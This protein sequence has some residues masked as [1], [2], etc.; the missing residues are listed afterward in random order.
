MRG[1]AWGYT[2]AIAAV[3]VMALPSGAAAFDAKL[4]RYP[5]LTDLVGTSVMVNFGTDITATSAVVKYGLNGTTCDTNTVT[6][7]RTF[8]LVNGVSEYQ[9]KAQ[10]AGLTPDTEYCYRV[11]FGS[12]QLDLLAPDASP[13]FRSQIP[14]GSSAPFKFAVW[15]NW[16]KTLA[17][18]N[19]HQA[20]VISQIAQSGARFA[21]TAGDNAYEAGSQKSYGDL[22]QVGD[23]TSA[24]FGPS[25]WK[26]AGASLPIFPTIG[27]H[28]HNNDV[29]LTN[30]P[31]DTAVSSSGGQYTTQTYCCTNGTNQADYPNGWYAFDAGLARFY[32]LETAWE[33]QNVGTA[34]LFKNDFDNHW[35]PNSPQYQW[36][37][38]D[39]ETH[40]RALRFAFHHFPMYSDQSATSSDT[41]LQGAN[42]LEGL[43]KLH[44]VTVDFAAHSH[45]YQRNS[46]PP[47]GVPN[48][49]SGGGGANLESIGHHSAG[50]SAMNQY[51]LG[52]S[53]V[54]D[55]G[56]ACGAAPV[57]T[58]KDQ[59]HHFLLV[60]VSG[61][62][63]TVTPTNSLGGTFDPITYN[64]PAQDADISVTKTDSPDP[65]LAG[66]QLTYD[67][68]VGNSGP[69][70]ATGVQLTDT[71]PSS[72]TFESATPS[73]GTCSQT[74]VIVSCSLGTVGNGAN[75]TVQIKVR[76]QATGSI[77]NT[78]TVA[79]NVNDPST[80]N[81]SASAATTV[82]PGADL[83]I[84][85]VDSPDPVLAGEVLTYAVG[86][87]NSGPST[88][89]N[90]S[91]SDTLPP[92]SVF[93][94]ATP[95]QGSCSQASG[96]VSC[97]IGNL[98][99]G[100]SPSISIQVRPQAAGTITSSASITSLTPDTDTAN[101]SASAQT[102]VDPAADLSITK[103]DSP[104][105]VRVGQQLTYA[106]TID[107]AGLSPA[108]DVS[109]SDTLPAGVTFDSATP[110]QGSC[111]EASGT[112]TC[113]LGTVAN[114][115]G[116]SVSITVTPQAA[117][118][119]TNTATVSSAVTDPSPADNSASAVTTVD[120]VADL[121][122]TKTDF[123]DPVLT[124]GLLTYT[125]TVQNAGPSDATGVALTDT[126][127][128]GVV[129]VSATPSQGSC[130]QAA[131]QV[132]CTLG[133]LAASG[134]ANAEV[135]VRPQSPGTITNQ[136]SITSSTHDPDTGNNTATAQTTVEPAADLSLTKSDSPD[137]V[138]VG[139]QLTYTLS[140]HNSGPAAATG[141]SLTDTLPSG[142]TFDSATPTQG[143]CSQASGTVTCS[144]GTIAS[145]V[146]AGVEIKVTPQAAGSI[147]NQ[148]SVSSS[149]S[150]PSLANNSASAVTTVDPVADLSITK[151]DSPDPVS[152]GEQLTYT[153]TVANAGPSPAT[154]V[155]VT[156]TLPGAVTYESATPSQG[157]CSEA[158]GTV[159][160]SLGTLASGANA[161]VQIVVRPTSG[162][163]ITNQASVSSP[164]SDPVLVNNSAS[165]TTTVDPVAD[166]AL[167]KDDS[168]DPVLSGQQ[169]TYT[170]TVSN[171]GPAAAPSVSLS[172]SLPAGATFVSASATQ[173]S[174]ARVGSTVTCALGTIANGSN[175]TVEI[176]VDAGAP[177]TL[178][179]EATVLS[180]A[181]DPDT[182][183]NSASA[184]TTVKPVADLALTKSDAPDPVLAGQL[185]TYTLGVSNGGPHDAIG[186]TV[187]DV[188]PSNSTFD[189]ASASQGS[190]SESAGT[191]TCALGT[192]ANG[193]TASVEIKVRPNNQ[194]SVTNEASVTSE[195][196]DLDQSNN[197]ASAE[198]TVDHAADLQL[199]KTDSPDPVLVGQE[200]TY[201]LTVHNDG[202]SETS[203]VA[204]SDTLPA[205]VTFISATTT[206]G[207]C[208]KSGNSV[209]CTLG[210]LADEETETVE[211]KVTAPAVGTLTNEANVVGI[212]VD[213]DTANNAASADTTVNPAADL[214]LTKS[215]S[216]DPVAAGDLLTYTLEVSNA[217][218]H[219]ATGATLTDTLPAGVLYES[220][221]PTQGTCSE[222]SGTVTCALGMIA[223]GA[224]ASVEVKVRPQEGGQITN[225]AAVSSDVGDPATGNNSASAETTVTPV[226]DL[227]LTKGDSPD[228]VLA[229]EPLT[230]LLTAQNAGP[231]SASAVELID[232]LPAGVTFDSATPTQGTCSESAGTVTC[233]LGAIA[234][235]Q[236]A[237]V[238]IEIRAP[239][240]GTITNQAGVASAD[241]DPVSSN[242]SASADT[243]V[244]AAAD[245]SLTKT[246]SPDPVLEGELLTYSLTAHN[247]GPQDA[248]GVSLTDTLPP[249]VTYDSATPTQGTCSELI[250]TVTC[251]L[252]TVA[253]GADA[254]VEIK[255]R[256]S[257]PGTLTN[258]A[259]VTSDV[260]DPDSA[261]T[262]ASAE[263]TVRPVADLALTKSD[264]PDPVLAGEL[265]TYTLGVSNSGPRDATAT[266]LTDTLPA[267]VTFDSATPTQG[268]C[269]E[270]SGTVTC[271]LGTIAD[272]GSASVEIKV[273]PQAAGT[274]NN[275]ASVASDEG[276]SNTADNSAGSETTVDPAADLSLTKSDSPDPVLAGEPLIYSLA[277]QN[278][279]PSSA[280]DVTLSDTLPAGVTYESATPTQ[281]ICSESGGTVTC[282]LGTI[283]DQQSASVE[284]RI[285]SA[286]PGLLS[287]SA[288]VVSLTADPDSADNSA[289]A[290]TTVTAAADLSLTKS[291][292]PDPVDVGG[293]LTY[294]LAVQNAGPQDATGASLTDTLPAGV[295]YES[296]TPSQGSCS[297]SSGTVTCALGTI[298]NGAGASVELK[299]RPQDAGT[300]TN[301]AAVTSDLADPDSADASAS[302]DTIVRA[303]ADLAL[304]KGDS[305][306]PVLVGELITYALSASNSG[307][308]DATGVTLTDTLPG[309]VTFESATPTQGSC[310]ESAGTVTCALGTIAPSQ[311]ASVVIE[312]RA[313]SPGTITNQAS[314]TSDVY[315][316]VSS[317]DSA[318]AETTVDP[319]ADLSL[320][321]TDSPDP[322]LAGELVAYTLTAHNAGPHDATGAT[323]TDPLPAGVTFDSATP[324]QGSCSESAG[325]V[326]CA[327]GTIADGGTATIQILVR[328][329][330]P[331][332]LSNEA[333]VS[334]ELGDPSTA[335]N[336]ATAET[337][338]TA[339]PVGYPRPAGASP[340]RASLVPAYNE[341]TAPNRSHGP[342]LDSP[343]CNPPAQRSGFLTVGTPD[344]N[345][346][347]AAMVGY[348]R[349]SSATGDP[350]TPADE[351]DVSIAF[352]T[353]DVRVP[354][355]LVDYTGELRASAVLRLTDRANG[356]TGNDTATMSGTTYAFTV[357]CTATAATGV[358]STCSLTTTA[359]ALLPN[360]VTEGK[361]AI[362]QL[363]EILVLD[364][365]PDGDAETADNTV[366]LR[367][368]LFIP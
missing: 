194:G 93:V 259:T 343:S 210:T 136:A 315:D 77:T 216:P 363:G 336:S 303:V 246:D 55:V 128:V 62:S 367:Q 171:S 101:N 72:V 158:S 115:A 140:V 9:W 98:P 177:G 141:T 203:G 37:K 21:V 321:T 133:A 11:Y 261:D 360:T 247:S 366:F 208:F 279:G 357:P 233:A 125:L 58:G 174:C 97:S 334:S 124:D 95:T 300:I 142:V 91:V 6:A 184:V 138:L 253:S 238:V 43:L 126:L 229:G 237:S 232:T 167:T 65:V 64:A 354:G 204:L 257:G 129:F 135:K 227:A 287:N 271:A 255:V 147:T 327:L 190:C 36:L 312:I 181:T 292:S 196:G 68:T 96:T 239:S 358:G 132:E 27:N 226:A 106:V 356:A 309:G 254:G 131:G 289:S 331:G 213:P 38:N 250:G 267:G 134:S 316:P 307:P 214:S 56:Y 260:A 270:A 31:Q 323:L 209:L 339:T 223:N 60:S 295:T 185:L 359:D 320:T 333:S 189:S 179:N 248:T 30:F 206:Q 186:V 29:L 73:Q 234:P 18:G 139:Q 195:A 317:N 311:Q 81:N 89:T 341:C 137:P 40:P 176:K 153:L 272:Q 365:G 193:G 8:I 59:V 24:V 85:N 12:A 105:P 120:P 325:T 53:N 25:Y 79:S 84:T 122:V 51:G 4:K 235:S 16:G 173:G 352:S 240:P 297:E 345:G 353:T 332:T 75:A 335:D 241:S 326:T 200:L 164:V 225:E 192:V 264:A 201:T 71:L 66:G 13:V 187:T 165:E 32:V 337:T 123:P 286:T 198:T 290:D 188:L 111:S 87:Q 22:Y 256:P 49:V 112:V 283:A 275:Q 308:Q 33:N 212:V 19:P 298:A 277:V 361:R 172:D 347:G 265:L 169:L 156:D 50:C 346:R 34:N 152:S 348:L 1:R 146:N 291:D 28:D 242:N 23:N 299:V 284:I 183:N 26:V 305:P 244:T 119:I 224:G 17:A 92:G 150:D 222:A 48:Y 109:V 249:G 63:V 46:A 274:I 302:E 14:A 220:A 251:A 217:G 100:A 2:A 355:T 329:S 155:S 243:T 182:A 163:S 88:A 282:A 20:N 351:A 306:D 221:I 161:T 276:D 108:T 236:Q 127:P 157:S 44:D 47:G 117:G 74:G 39:L 252:G 113:S 90:V 94:S 121:S 170:L 168:P 301:Q 80:G 269:S 54:N 310:S 45:N 349:L 324:S 245:L 314:V 67:L 278:A 145:G 57:P 258:Q 61:T 362:W 266:V 104:D 110:S 114:G 102:T 175:V 5:Y 107:N 159:T 99:S 149:V 288:N 304:T 344:A 35:G 211:I 197:S 160:C 82:N 280:A 202:P 330:A 368:G 166:L 130:T 10:I 319:A 296:A 199:T 180:T 69:R 103:T 191:V 231:S 143:S 154:G 293:E 285:R 144:L 205:G 3:V 262:N 318:S 116:A 151:T 207:S 7:T 263:T 350:G 218:P 294:T 162:S 273:R 41:Y 328:P 178:T 148:A 70:A 364:G 78:A 281:G 322:V 42:S 76:P 15:G 52:W 86:L 268:T 313:P 340:L 338:V 342:P 219:D 230:Y 228:P 83:S 215:D 118:S